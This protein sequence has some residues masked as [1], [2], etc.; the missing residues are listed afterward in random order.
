MESDELF[1]APE[2]TSSVGSKS[3]VSFV[4]VS[5]LL[6]DVGFIMLHRLYLQQ[7]LGI[8]F[9]IESEQSLPEQ[10]QHVKELVAAIAGLWLLLTRGDYLYACWTGV[11]AWIFMDDTLQ[12]HEQ[13]GTWLSTQWHATPLGMTTQSFGELLLSGML[14]AA[15]LLLLAAS[16]R[17]GAE[18]ARQLSVRLAR[19]FAALVCAGIVIDTL[20]VLVR[21]NP[22]HYRL[23][24][25]EEG[26]EMIAI[27]LI[28]WTMLA[29]VERH[30]RRP[31]LN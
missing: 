3:A 7:A 17:Q 16:W 18:A 19:C 6:L 29:A 4:L 21:A 20:H 28:A 14:G 22:W 11:F 5:M 30:G 12:F 31:A 26:G 9:S 27:T 25:L 1:Y 10:Y 24:I 8:G 15:F 13:F 23:G 2:R